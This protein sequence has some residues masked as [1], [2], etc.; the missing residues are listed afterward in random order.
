MNKT[1][2][3]ALAALGALSSL[4]AVALLSPAPSDGPQGEVDT[5]H[6]T[7]SVLTSSVQTAPSVMAAEAASEA[8]EVSP[9]R[10]HEVM[11]SLA[12][13]ADFGAIAA[14]F[15][16]TVLRVPGRSGYGLLLLPEGVSAADISADGRVAS[17]APNARLV[18]AEKKKKE[19]ESPGRSQD[20]KE[21]DEDTTDSGAP[22]LQ[23]HLDEVDMPSGVDLSGVTVAVLDTGVAYESDKIQG[24]SYA[25]AS[26]M[27]GVTIVSPRDFVDSD[28]QPLDEHQ[29]GT[30]IAS[31]IVGQGDVPGVAAGAALMPLRVLDEANS[32]S[33][34]DLIEAIGWAVDNGAD[35]INMSLTFPPG[36]VP[37][38]ALLQVIQEA[39]DAGVVLV[40]ASGNDGRDDVPCWPAS[41]P[42]VISVAS[43]VPTLDAGELTDKAA[44]YSNQGT[45][46]DL[47]AP[48]GNV[49]TDHNSDGL[50]D[51]IV[52][53]TIALN[54]PS[55]TGLWMFEGTSQAAAVVSG[56]AAWLV[57]SGGSGEQVRDALLYSSKFWGNNSFAHGN[58]AGGLDISNA[59]AELDNAAV[60]APP[61][62]LVSMLAWPEWS[63]LADGSEVMSA[64]AQIT[65]IH[66]D[67]S[68][69]TDKLEVHGT[70]WG[71]EGPESVSCNI[72]TS[73]TSCMLETSASS[74]VSEM[75]WAIQIDAIVEP[76]VELP[77]RP[78][79]AMFGSDGLE[80]LLAAIGDQRKLK[81]SILAL[82]WSEEVGG[83]DG[84]AEGY[85]IV[86]SGTGLASIPLSVVFTPDAMP[87]GRPKNIDLDLD[88][89]GLS[90]IPLG[91]LSVQRINIDGTGLSSSPLAFSSQKLVVVNGTGLA[92][93]PL[94]I[95]A[96]DIFAPGSG[97]IDAG[98]GLNGSTLL[99]S[100]STLVG[101][102][103]GASASHTDAL[104]SD[105]WVS[106]DGY[107]VG[108]LLVGSGAA[109]VGLT[110]GGEST[111]G[112]HGAVE[113]P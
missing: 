86:N 13:G 79:V 42:L 11:I 61:E 96:T 89:T 14:D 18:G 75:A 112:S 52:A 62:Y 103:T 107:E 56:A 35:V 57:A 108:S 69:P 99:M 102:S 68:F 10:D 97:S 50:A 24:V 21:T 63:V 101:A 53:E 36:Y 25:Q 64:A 77:R 9:Y 39:S 95:G 30:H 49:L 78:G 88:G 55:E 5:Q 94:G 60:L 40:A 93:S 91:M 80:I 100:T 105:G 54:D 23:W 73:H 33:E 34:H 20:K 81:N 16:A 113:I 1:T 83:V 109:A 31:L 29:H 82:E 47:M 92:S 59:L 44:P 26:S 3:R 8:A 87:M 48:G 43:F 84:V 85:S 12:D 67:G 37:S 106:S 76:K 45:G 111:A 71:P 41:S 6:R 32:G 74:R 66:P 28:D 70:A 90:S 46:V 17:L 27:S 65:V 72:S 2:L 98:L 22:E 58:G 4:S 110:P 104:L 38:P 19:D 7:R 15:G 51:G